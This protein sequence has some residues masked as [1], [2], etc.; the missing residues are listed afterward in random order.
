[1]I[2][3]MVQV[4][5]RYSKNEIHDRVVWINNFRLFFGLAFFAG[6]IVL[7]ALKVAMTLD[8][9]ILFMVG[10]AILVY[11]LLCF[12]YLATQRP[13]LNE[14]LF[15]TVFMAMVD[16]FAITVFVYFSGGHESPYFVFYLLGLTT[17]VMG[18]PYLTTSVFA[19]AGLAAM[20]YDLMIILTNFHLLPFFSR[21]HGRVALNPQDAYLGLLNALIVP[22][23]IF[24]FAAGFFA[25]SK[26]METV[27]LESDNKIDAEKNV[28]KTLSSFAQVYFILTHVY[29]PDE[30]LNQA[31]KKLLEILKLK[32]G[33]ILTLDS[34]KKLVCAANHN[35][36]KGVIENFE[37][38]PFKEMSELPANLKGIVLG[39]EFIHNWSSWKLVFHGKPQGL[40]VFFGAEGEEWIDSR[41]KESLD[42]IAEEM[43]AAIYYGGLFKKLTPK[44]K[45][46]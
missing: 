13:S 5:A 44:S 25:I 34:Q 21:L 23:V 35:V 37:H 20:F 10:I 39:G 33:M 41:Y 2:V 24:F 42:A 31:L 11:S 8:V 9:L 12:A 40:L 27:R 1:M 46:E 38:K 28:E 18:I 45:E 14:L 30:M 3:P 6:L 43:S 36:Q 7:N 15:F 17:V 16:M 4:H 22:I 19:L 29:K 26:F 32:S